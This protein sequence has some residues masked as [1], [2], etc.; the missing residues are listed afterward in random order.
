MKSMTVAAVLFFLSGVVPSAFGLEPIRFS[1]D[2]DSTL[3]PRERAFFDLYLVKTFTAAKIEISKPIVIKT[4]KATNLNEV[5]ITRCFLKDSLCLGFGPFITIS[6]AEG[7]GNQALGGD[8]N[9]KD[10]AFNLEMK[11]LQYL[12][13]QNEWENLIF[14]QFFVR[15]FLQGNQGHVQALHMSPVE[16][17]VTYKTLSILSRSHKIKH[18][19]SENRLHGIYMSASRKMGVGNSGVHSLA[20]Y[21][22][23][24]RH[25]TVWNHINNP[26]VWRS[27]L[28]HELGHW[29]DHEVLT[30]EDQ[31]AFKD[32][33]Q[34]K[35]PKSSSYATVDDGEDFAEAF[36]HY[37]SNPEELFRTCPARASFFYET[38]GIG[39]IK[40]PKIDSLALSFD[41]GIFFPHI[42]ELYSIKL[43]PEKTKAI[44]SSFATLVQYRI[45]FLKNESQRDAQYINEMPQPW[46]NMAMFARQQFSKFSEG[47]SPPNLD[48]YEDQPEISRV[49]KVI[50]DQYS[51]QVREIFYEENIPTETLRKKLGV[52]ESDESDTLISFLKVNRFIESIDRFPLYD[53]HSVSSNGVL[54][55]THVNH[56]SAEVTLEKNIGPDKKTVNY[57][58]DLEIGLDSESD[59]QNP[60]PLAESYDN[61][62][63]SIQDNNIKQKIK[64]RDFTKRWFHHLPYKPTFLAYRDRFNRYKS[65]DVPN[66]FDKDYANHISDFFENPKDMRSKPPFTKTPH[67]KCPDPVAFSVDK[68]V[69]LARIQTTYKTETL[70]LTIPIDRNILTALP[71]LQFGTDI[72]IHWRPDKSGG[73]QSEDHSGFYSKVQTIGYGQSSKDPV[74]LFISSKVPYVAGNCKMKIVGVTLFL[75][76]EPPCTGEKSYQFYIPLE[77]KNLLVTPTAVKESKNNVIES[78]FNLKFVPGEDPTDLVSQHGQISI[79][80]KEPINIVGNFSAYDGWMTLESMLS[81]EMLDSPADNF[82]QERMISLVEVIDHDDGTQTLVFKTV[83]TFQIMTSDYYA[84]D[85]YLN[86]R[87]QKIWIENQNIHIRENQTDGLKKG[88]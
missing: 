2:S 43:V 1:F 88:G 47:K 22:P 82:E 84:K 19:L 63:H 15:T 55:G 81:T 75:D 28:F 10:Q 76:Y 51:N 68:H 60:K 12:L 29:V 20:D 74:V 27:T 49:L 66:Y 14:S 87:G 77:T 38:L 64:T 16:Q 83:E 78:D 8:K 41:N 25:V 69:D 67:P 18:A 31:E 5:E 34:K 71:G 59:H 26:T 48:W 65:L 52:Y 57:L 53:F 23:E 40:T 45:D 37:F 32:L 61:Q 42:L 79:H 35:C 80:L 72:Y 24:H 17:Q 54:A 86:L 9:P 39:L 7:F 30:K 13:S 11:I 46:K 58:K 6:M 33:S 62:D 44:P 70:D 50:F 56:F 36:E 3:S 85:I 21:N 4:H 73:C